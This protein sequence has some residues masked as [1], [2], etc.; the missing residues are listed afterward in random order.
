MDSHAASRAAL[1]HVH[2][3]QQNLFV[4]QP[5]AER[6]PPLNCR[7]QKLTVVISSYQL[8][9]ALIWAVTYAPVRA[10]KAQ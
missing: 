2:A 4:M 8:A 5:S 3:T 7:L 6:D 9:F 10:V 1:P